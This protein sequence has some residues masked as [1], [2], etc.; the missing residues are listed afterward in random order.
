MPG[1][2]DG[3]RI[4][5]LRRPSTQAVFANQAPHLVVGQTKRFGTECLIEILCF[6]RRKEQLPL[7][8]IDRGAQIAVVC[9]RRV[10]RG[11]IVVGVSSRCAGVDSRCGLLPGR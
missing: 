7:I 9:R 11:V 4:I 5:D 3:I 6:Q 8:G 2:L 1:P 10:L